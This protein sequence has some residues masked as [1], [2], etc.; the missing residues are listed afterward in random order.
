MIERYFVKGALF[1]WAAPSPIT[2]QP[3]DGAIVDSPRVVAPMFYVGLDDQVVD[4]A[5]PNVSTL[6]LR[7]DMGIAHTW[8][9][10]IHGRTATV[11]AAGDVLTGFMSGCWITMWNDGGGRKV[12]HV[13]TIE[14][15][16][17]TEP[18]NS[19]V[20]NTFAQAMPQNV[21]G[22]NP[23]RAFDAGDI[24]PLLTRMR[25]TPSA[26]VLSLVTASNEFYAIL[27]LQRMTERG[28][29]ICAGKK[30]MDAVGYDGLYNELITT[31]PRR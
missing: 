30:R 23:A 12:G 26:Q 7:K 19:T 9:N 5:L 17:K 18:P 6:G 2:S 29:W 15:A 24:M 3:K 4:H 22:Y 11:Q 31:R 25:G 13:G 1:N 28:I 14:S 16:A 20:K 27:L 10:Y 8:L 21:Q